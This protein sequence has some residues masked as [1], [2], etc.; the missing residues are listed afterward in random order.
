MKRVLLLGLVTLLP[1]W[2]ACGEDWSQYKTADEL[3]SRLQTLQNTPGTTDR[4]RYEEQLN[5]LSSGLWE[6][7]TRFAT[8]PRRWDAK[9]VR[10]QVE[11]TLARMS[12]VSTDSAALLAAAKEI[13]GAADAS[14]SVKSDA[15][16]LA[17]KIHLQALTSSGATI[18]PAARAAVE[19]DIAQFRKDYPGDTRT[20]IIR[21]QLAMFLKVRDPA[22]AESMFRELGN[23]QNIRVA[24]VA[25][26][27]LGTLQATQKLGKEPLD[28]KFK[29]VD[30]SDFDLAKLRG[31]VVL[32]DFWATWC[33][34]CRMEMP[35]VVAAYSQYHKAGFEIVGI[36]LDQ[37]KEKLVG[38]TQQAGM[39]WPQYFDGKGWANDISR[40]YGINSIPSAWLVDKKGY[41]RAT[42]V[43]GAALA[44]QVKAL[45]A[46]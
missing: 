18:D 17:G 19:A 30:G 10:V 38:Y 26:Q 41:I 20:D 25:Q 22:A 27:E 29:A 14:L 1:V 5:A 12:G 2:L 32:V 35:N 4:T 43:R 13:A 7:E 8:D 44:G 6:F 21:V 15:R 36:S 40:R 3:W 37:S 16:F 24:A 33:G 39:T 23:S 28:L 34:P 31:K 46:E 45:L 42:E 9:L 11:D